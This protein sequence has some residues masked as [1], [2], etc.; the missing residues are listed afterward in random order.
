[1]RPLEESQR[2]RTMRPCIS[3]DPAGTPCD[4]GVI[5]RMTVAQLDPAHGARLFKCDR[6]CWKSGLR[7]ARFTNAYQR[8]PSAPPRKMTADPVQCGGQ[9]VPVHMLAFSRHVSI[10][11]LLP[12][13]DLRITRVFSCVARGLGGRASSRFIRGCSWRVS[14]VD[15]GRGHLGEHARLAAYKVVS[16]LSLTAVLLV[17][18]DLLVAWL[19]LDV[20]RFRLL[21]AREWHAHVSVGGRSRRCELYGGGCNGLAVPRCDEL[22]RCLRP[23]WLQDH[24]RHVPILCVGGLDQVRR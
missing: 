4:L 16:G 10:M 20:Y 23:V 8:R 13:V 19:R 11:R 7:A 15:G 24:R 14:V 12:L 22:K 9:P 5:A 2:P 18:P 1:M 17:R 3:R 21:L 6:S